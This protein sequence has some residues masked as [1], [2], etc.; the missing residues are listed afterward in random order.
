MGESGSERSF[1]NVLVSTALGVVEKGGIESLSMRKLAKLLGYS[2]MKFY[3][4]CDSKEQLFVLMAEEICRQQWEVVQAVP[5]GEDAVENV[6]RTTGAAFDYYLQH[7]SSAQV[8]AQ[9]RF[10]GAQEKIGPVFFAITQHYQELL[11]ATQLPALTHPEGL[12]KA[13]NILR[14]F[15]LGSLSLLSFDSLERQKERVREIFLE[16]MKCLLLG[17]KEWR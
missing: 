2:T 7:P 12:D 3:S 13:T 11:E 5:L 16:G 9:V 6:M 4:E 17:W 15:I 14:V 1:Q 10:E 8:L